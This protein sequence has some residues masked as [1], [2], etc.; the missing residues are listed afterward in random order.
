MLITGLAGDLQFYS[1]TLLNMSGG[2]PVCCL[3]K[4]CLGRS[5]CETFQQGVIMVLSP[6]LKAP[7]SN[8][9]IVQ[10]T[11]CICSAYS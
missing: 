5:L 6:T 9:V 4:T 1:N 7:N 11:H 8:F 2:N 10:N 3:F